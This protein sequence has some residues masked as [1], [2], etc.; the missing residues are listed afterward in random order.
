MK[1]PI[2]VLLVATGIFLSQPLSALAQ[3]A[4]HGGGP[5]K[6]SVSGSSTSRAPSH[7]ASSYHNHGGKYRSHPTRS[8][9]YIH[10]GI[11]WGPTWG[12]WTWPYGYYYYPAY[13]LPPHMP[14]VIQEQP[15][16]SYMEQ[17]R[18]AEDHDF[19]YYCRE[20]KGYYPDVPRCPSGW[21]KV[22]PEELSPEEEE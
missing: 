15:E 17:D 7:H 8:R 6:G 14:P 4:R 18:E 19:L 11:W 13:P 10:G 16:T 12:P 21:Q 3:D 2:L 20:P 1:A 9:V 5:G 22:D